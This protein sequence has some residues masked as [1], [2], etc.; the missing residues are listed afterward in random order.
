MI[1]RTLSILG[2]ALACA[3]LAASAVAAAIPANVA[4]YTLDP[5]R[6]ALK[7]VFKQAGAANQ[8]RFRKLA[9][10]L[11]FGDTNLPASKLDITID[12]GS[13]DTGD[14]E[15]D[16]TLRGPEL[17]DMARFPQAR[18]KSTQFK[19][20]SAGRYEVI[21]KLT[22]RDVTRE[23]HVPFSFRTTTEKGE[24]VGYMTGRV[25]INR[26]DFGVGQGEWQATEQVANEVDVSFGLRFSAA[27]APA[28]AK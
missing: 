13:L 20:L 21:G 24:P 3:M 18:F 9:G 7:F 8:G 17:F 10:T 12:I 2:A 28:A 25:T 5:A 4:D 16:K 11:R 26:L 6:S 22:I 1:T 19:R 27:A 15:R 23:L 14:D